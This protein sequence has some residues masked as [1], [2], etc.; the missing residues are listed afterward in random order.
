MLSN[1]LIESSTHYTDVANIKFN[2]IFISN[3]NATWKENIC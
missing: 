1:N 2:Y 3:E